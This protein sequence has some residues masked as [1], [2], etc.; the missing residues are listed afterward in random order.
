MDK[1]P[2]ILFLM[3]DQHRPD[4]FGYAGNN[5]VKTPNLDKLAET[6]VVFH[7]AYTPHPQCIPARQ[8]MMAGQL[9]KTCKCERFEDDLAPGYETF[10][11]LFSRY[12]YATVACGKLHHTGQDQMQ[13]WTQRIGS[14][15]YVTSNHIP[16][17]KE[18]EFKSYIRPKSETRWSIEKEIKRAGIGEARQVKEDAYTV[19]GALNFIDEYFNSPYYDKERLQQPLLLKVSLTQPH[20]PYTAEADKFNYYLNRVPLYL[21][22]QVSEHPYLR[23]KEIR[24]G[25]DVSEREMRRCVAAYYSLVEK[26]DEHFGTILDRLEYVGQD[27]DDWIIIYTSDHGEMLGEHSVWMK[28]K[29]YESSARVPLIIRWPNKFEGGVTR[30]ENVNLCDLFA[31][32]CELTGIPI[33]DNLDSRSLVPLLEGQGDSWENESISQYHGKYLMIKWDHL[34]YQY[35]GE[36][37]PEVLFDLKRDPKET[38]DYIEDPEYDEIIQKFRSRRNELGFGPNGDPNYKNAGYRSNRMEE[39]K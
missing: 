6:G 37:L 9:P 28:Q 13:G 35:Y 14:E 30:Y 24:V 27:L 11:R 17:K 32:L 4:L 1:R 20:Y 15:M 38:V 31:T 36:D 5:V 22:Q 3:D 16:G 29:F 39:Q 26:A 25:I 21:D 10:A 18:E 7:Q 12:A 33:P 19:Q 34:K 2:N 23:E 8:S